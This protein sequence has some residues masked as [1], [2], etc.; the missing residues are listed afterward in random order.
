MSPLRLEGD[1]DQPHVD[2]ARPDEIAAERPLLATRHFHT[3]D[4]DI[5]KVRDKHDPNRG[6]PSDKPADTFQR[7]LRGGEAE[8]PI[9]KR[10]SFPRD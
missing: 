5:A 1:Y 9:G 6:N 4:T 2:G 8:D 3:Q 7:R 10:T